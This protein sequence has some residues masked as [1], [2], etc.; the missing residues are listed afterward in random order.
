MRL[1][2]RITALFWVL[3]PTLAIAEDF[4]IETEGLTALPMFVDT[5]IRSSKG[6]ES[7]ECKL[8]GKSVDLSD[9]GAKTGF[10]V[11]TANAC[12]WGAAQGPIWVVRA[13]A[14]SAELVL[15][16]VGYSVTLGQS[17]Q[18]GLRHLAI[19]AGTATRYSYSL[20]KFDGATYQRVQSYMFTP[21][22]K[23]L[24]RSHQKICPWEM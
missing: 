14:D 12:A 16:Y 7:D 1:L 13:V 5:A 22:D 20:W 18:H 21:E 23:A 11:T 19:S 15:H 17:K 2:S 9:Q 8:I 10:V 24:C 3:V 6:F 4:T